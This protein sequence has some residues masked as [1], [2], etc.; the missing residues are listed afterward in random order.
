[1]NLLLFSV[2]S[3]FLLQI[4]HGVSFFKK[5]ILKIKNKPESNLKLN[6]TVCDKNR[7]NS[8]ELNEPKNKKTPTKKIDDKLAG[9]DTRM[10]ENI[11]ENAIFLLKI[12]KNIYIY[13]LLKKLTSEYLSQNAK[14]KA[15]Y[16]Y[17]D[18]VESNEPNRTSKFATDLTRGGLFESFYDEFD[19]R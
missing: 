5:S 6:Y 10:E 16:L 7:G 14:L 8:T 13:D 15:W 19:W 12:Q 17:M 18:Y 3:L 4:P 9:H 11:T 2:F 1:M